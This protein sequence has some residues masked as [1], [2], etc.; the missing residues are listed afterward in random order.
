MKISQIYAKHVI[1]SSELRKH[2]TSKWKPIFPDNNIAYYL[3]LNETFHYYTLLHQDWDLYVHYITSS[4]QTPETHATQRKKEFQNLLNDFSPT[5]LE[6]KE[7]KIIIK[8][9]VVE[10]GLHRLS[11]LFYKNII[12]DELPDQWIK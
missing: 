8:D 1:Y 5:L 6:K 2:I 4:K 9:N 11:I 12:T 10:D 7:N 3:P